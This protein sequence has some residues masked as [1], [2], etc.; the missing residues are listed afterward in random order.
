[1]AGLIGKKLGMTNI[2]DDEGKALPVTL[3]EAGP[4]AVIGIKTKD[5]NGYTSIVLGF[6]DVKASK[7]NKPQRKVFENLKINPKRTVREIIVDHSVAYKIGEVLNVGQFK[8]GDYV[9]VSGTTIG[10]GFQGGMK[11]WG[12][13]GGESGHGSMF[14]RAPGS[15]GSSSYP[16]RVFKGHKMPGHMGAAKRTAQ[17]LKVVVVDEEN[18]LLAIHGSLPGHKGGLLIVK[19][20]KKRPPTADSKTGSAQE[21]KKA[22]KK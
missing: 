17:N 4:C 6:E 8:A 16:S 2:F 20:A 14:H 18:H 13:S 10:K 22:D 9:D 11:R 19:H 3:I 5:K 7:V 12:W 15:I 21:D 1:M